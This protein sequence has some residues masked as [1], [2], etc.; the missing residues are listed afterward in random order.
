[1]RYVNIKILVPD[2]SDSST[3][4]QIHQ[5][6]FA[7]VSTEFSLTFHMQ[8]HLPIHLSE[9]GPHAI[10]LYSIIIIIIIITVRPHLCPFDAHWPKKFAI[11]HG[12]LH[13]RDVY[14]RCGDT[15][16]PICL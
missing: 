7:L 15:G 3:Y 2:I 8:I 10:N 13:Q 9:E 4:N 14:D 1:M 12:R 11:S 6:T 5:S 16:G